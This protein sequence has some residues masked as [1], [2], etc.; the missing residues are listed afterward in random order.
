MNIKITD[1]SSLD[2]LINRQ[3]VFRLWPSSDEINF[4]LAEFSHE[5]N[6]YWQEKLNRY[7]DS[8]GCPQSAAFIMVAMIV[9]VLY[10][11]IRPSGFSIKWSDVGLGV[12]VFILSGIVGKIFGIFIGKI[13]LIKTV[14]MI[15]KELN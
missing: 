2:D 10:L 4:N 9:F 14:K 13:K 8:C 5:K 11:I 7:H 12:L 3:S 15:K 6:R 1:N